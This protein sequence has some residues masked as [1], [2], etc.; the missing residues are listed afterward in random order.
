MRNS[1]AILPATQCL[2]NK[3]KVTIDEI[4]ECDHTGTIV[5]CLKPNGQFHFISG[6]SGNYSKIGAKRN[7]HHD[8]SLARM[9][10]WEVVNEIYYERD[11]K[12]SAINFTYAVPPVMGK[13]LAPKAAM[14]VFK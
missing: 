6:A 11:S 1:W 14:A 7:V 9:G 2:F 3:A 12:T 13:T 10:T 4:A 8:Q 5:V